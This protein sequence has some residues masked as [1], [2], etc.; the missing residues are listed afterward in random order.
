MATSSISGIDIFLSKPILSKEDV[1]Q[2]LQEQTPPGKSSA[3]SLGSEIV[4]FREG[5]FIYLPNDL[6]K[7]F[8]QS[9][10]D[11]STQFKLALERVDIHTQSGHM[12]SLG[13]QLSDN[14]FTFIPSEGITIPQEEFKIIANLSE[15]KPTYY[16]LGASTYNQSTGMWEYVYYSQKRRTHCSH[17]GDYNASINLFQYVSITPKGNNMKAGVLVSA[18]QSSKLKDYRE[19]QPFILI[20]SSSGNW[21]IPVPLDE[22]S[23]ENATMCMPCVLAFQDGQVFIK[24]LSVIIKSNT[25]VDYGPTEE[26]KKIIL[27]TEFEQVSSLE[28]LSFEV[29]QVVSSRSLS[30]AE[31]QEHVMWETIEGPTIINYLSIDPEEILPQLKYIK[32]VIFQQ[33][34][35]FCLNGKPDPLIHRVSNL[36]EVNLGT[37]EVGC[38]V[39]SGDSNGPPST[40]MCSPI[41]ETQDEVSFENIC[42]RYFRSDSF[43]VIFL[44]EKCQ[45][46]MTTGNL[47]FQGVIILVIESPPVFIGGIPTQDFLND[48][49][50]TGSNQWSAPFSILMTAIK[51]SGVYQFY[52]LGGMMDNPLIPKKCSYGQ[53]L[54]NSEVVTQKIY[55]LISENIFVGENPV[56]VK[57]MEHIL[58]NGYK[59]PI[60]EFLKLF[61][62]SSFE[63]MEENQSEIIN[64]IEQLK[65][66]FNTNELKK[67]MS[68]FLLV[69]QSHV[70]KVK[71]E[72]GTDVKDIDAFMNL[73]VDKIEQFKKEK[74]EQT[75][76]KN[77]LKALIAV[78]SSSSISSKDKHTQSMSLKQ[79]QKAEKITAN[80]KS[81][82]QITEDETGESFE[83]FMENYYN[84]VGAIVMKFN[85]LPPYQQIRN[86]TFLENGLL[87]FLQQQVLTPCHRCFNLDAITASTLSLMSKSNQE[88]CSHALSNISGLGLMIPDSDRSESCVML[89]ISDLAV[90]MMDPFNN[91]WP[92]TADK[93]DFAYFRMMLSANLSNNLTT[94]DN[95]LSPS[96][97]EIRWLTATILMNSMIN[98]T[99]PSSEE[100][101]DFDS[102]I[103][104][105]MRGLMT[106]YLATISCGQNP[107]CYIWQ[108]ISYSRPTELPKREY[109]WLMLKNV[110]HLW[111]YTG[112]S[113]KQLKS[114]LIKFITRIINR[115]VQVATK[116]LQEQKKQKKKD[117]QNQIKKIF[118]INFTWF[119][120][121]K[122]ALYYLL[123]K[124]D[125]SFIEDI[126]RKFLWN[127]DGSQTDISEFTIHDGE[128]IKVIELLLERPRRGR[129]L[130]AAL[131]NPDF[132]TSQTTRDIIEASFLKRV[133]PFLN[134]SKMLYEINLKNDNHGIPKIEFEIIQA[135]FDYLKETFQET[136]Q[137]QHIETLF[138][139]KVIG[140]QFILIDFERIFLDKRYKPSV[141]SSEEREKYISSF[142]VIEID[143]EQVY[144][145]GWK[146]FTIP[147]GINSDN[148]T[149]SK[150]PSHPQ[151]SLSELTPLM[152]VVAEMSSQ[153]TT[154]TQA[155]IHFLEDPDTMTLSSI[156]ELER[157]RGSDFKEIFKF[158]FPNTKTPFMI[159]I[160]LEVIEF[161]LLNW[162]S[163]NNLIENQIVDKF[164]GFI[165]K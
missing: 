118:Y 58:F 104:K 45:E 161:C 38:P 125:E 32:Q 131:E 156:V 90:K 138:E 9:S 106:Q 48:I 36:G 4:F 22:A 54:G 140:E 50:Q 2:Y 121:Y 17:S 61:E 155:L 65:R 79:H 83:D 134:L 113:E 12:H 20:S 47:R 136:S 160:M 124:Q 88:Y 135:R 85:I 76:R 75:R 56:N 97:P 142:K 115:T 29:P 99:K 59:L 92:N 123:S 80:L 37:I 71:L 151:S 95:P 163:D 108:L 57:N 157:V 159:K 126:R 23:I 114:Q 162:E 111:K 73:Q 43:P 44:N 6:S 141:V 27:D 130:R 13:F 30:L 69:L 60:T 15:K 87:S 137:G 1:E 11:I 41:P 91:S 66:I 146:P 62:E 55:S 165:Y 25:M 72:V 133:N 147:P 145:K 101:I 35:V 34:P 164:K 86:K 53:L 42:Q 18:Y 119:E 132:E 149:L 100:A 28:P 98:I 81:V 49:N 10:V 68:S 109:E 24:P 33:C 153:T 89:L 51:I 46:R 40:L 150:A 74:G 39:L 8:L 52:Y 128:K 7:E 110:C 127:L 122:K 120:A 148:R 103:C 5:M 158:I 96:S 116:P 77:I 139:N 144:T 117:T 94:R 19:R 16:D 14:T 3:I 78:V 84:E 107:L 82:K 21:I 129:F 154:Q 67:I 143:S 102:G 93:P 31:E 112:W 152:K 64:A 63:F 70:L 105:I 26:M